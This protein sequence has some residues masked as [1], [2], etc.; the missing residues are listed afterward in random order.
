ML[1]NCFNLRYLF[2]TDLITTIKAKQIK[3]LTDSKFMFTIIIV[4]DILSDE[5]QQDAKCRTLANF[6]ETNLSATS[7]MNNTLS[8]RQCFG[9]QYVFRV[10]MGPY[11]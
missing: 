3:R 10:P 9:N 6:I 8:L 4:N 5:L 11:Y 1:D 2:L 7:K